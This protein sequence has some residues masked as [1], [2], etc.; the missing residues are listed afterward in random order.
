MSISVDES[1]TYSVG[2]RFMIN[3]PSS[4]HS[5]LP[6]MGSPEGGST[7][8]LISRVVSFINGVS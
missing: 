8:S 4:S 1:D 5:F 3:N 6:R 2:V 7:N